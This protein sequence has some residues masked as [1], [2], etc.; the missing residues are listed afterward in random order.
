MKLSESGGGAS[1][2]DDLASGICPPAEDHAPTVD[3]SVPGDDSSIANMTGEEGVVERSGD[4]GPQGPA[5][6]SILLEYSTDE[7]DE[8]GCLGDG[9]CQKTEAS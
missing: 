9:V 8:D 5:G 2:G 1:A 7:V 3:G 6:L 4:R